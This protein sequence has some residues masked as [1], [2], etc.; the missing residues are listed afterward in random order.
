MLTK[1]IIPCLDIK[2]G[3]VVK[4]IR[5]KK[6]R[7]AG[8]PV[9]I[10]S[11]YYKQGADEIVFL[12]ITASYEKRNILIDVVKKVSDVI[13]IPLTVGGGTRTLKDIRMILYSGADKISI[14]TAAV[15]NPQL[16]R[17]ASKI[18]GSQCIVSSIDVKRVYVAEELE[19]PGKT[20]L[21]TPQGKCWWSAY[22]YGG[23][24]KLNM[25]AIKWAEEVVELGAG[26]ILI[27]SLDFDGT[28]QG[29]DLIFLRELSERV[30][31]PI[32]ASSGAGTLKHILD[33]FTIGKADAAL[34]AS[35]FHYNTYTIK[36]VKKYLATHGVQVRL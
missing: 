35:I 15:K 32:I 28:Q 13:F 25:D 3:R 14:N 8:D 18:F 11:Y 2:N 6:L 1:R 30:S 34:A 16:I 7:D 10:A 31:V 24:E 27:S 33:S 19:A 12:D 4:G 22:I 9:E 23:K 5:F 21:D 17:E 36:D 29:Y 20:V 26:E